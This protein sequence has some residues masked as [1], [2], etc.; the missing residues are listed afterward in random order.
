[1]LAAI[2][3]HWDGLYTTYHRFFSHLQSKLNVD[4]G[5]TQ[6]SKI[7]IGSDEEAALTKAIKQCF[8][9]SANI[10]C[11][12]HLEENV[13]RYLT[14]NI[15]VSD[16]VRKQ[17]VSDIF[18]KHGLT[19]FN[20]VKKFE[21]KLMKLS[22]KYL[23]YLPSFEEYFR[24]TAQKIRSGVLQPRIENKWLPINWKNNSCESMNH[25][26]KLSANWKTMKLPDLIERLYKIVKLQQAECRRALYG[27]GNYEL[28][29]WM[30]KC[31]IQYVHWTQKTK[32]EKEALFAKFMKG[33]PAKKKTVSSTDGRLTIPKTCKTAKK[34]G[35]RK[36]VK[37]LKTITRNRNIK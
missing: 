16:K 37:S 15:G 22:D 7:V 25:I 13:R 1:M 12:R 31:K 34:P 8:P 14:N 36:R 26:I 17:V 10:L 20:E 29:P 33:M 28:A 35:Q 24:K 6:L 3:L 23:K 19:S 5:G 4:I 27:Q 18:G 9:S 30:S 2:Y 32:E 11:S 21:L